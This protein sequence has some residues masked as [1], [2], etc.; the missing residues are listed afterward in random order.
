MTVALTVPV[1]LSF[2]IAE[3]RAVAS[4]LRWLLALCF[5]GCSALVW[6]R[7]RLFLWTNIPWPTDW[8]IPR[9]CRAMLNVLT[10]V[11]VLILTAIVAWLVFH[12]VPFAG[13]VPA[14]VFA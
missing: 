1:L 14:S 9:L 6:A 8:N 12:E 11:P 2:A 5:L 13:P 7:Q 4:A 3:Q 10:V